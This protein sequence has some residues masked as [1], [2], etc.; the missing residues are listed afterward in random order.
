M[1]QHRCEI[2]IAGFGGQGVVLSGI[3]LARAGMLDGRQVVQNQSYGAEARGGGARAEVILA[4]GPILYTDVLH[5]DVMVVM[6]QLAC[7]K[8]GADL[9]PTGQLITESELVSEIP[10][11]LQDRSRGAPF[12]QMAQDTFERPIVANMVALGYCVGCTEVVTRESLEQA[13]AELVPAGTAE[14]NLA[15]VAAGWE[16]AAEPVAI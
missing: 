14:L 4:D 7:D 16:L 12:T 8:Y 6:S 1:E 13:V 2:R 5:P 15:A 11:T 9:T 3:V 10:I